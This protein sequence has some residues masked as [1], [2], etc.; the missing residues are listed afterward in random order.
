MTVCTQTAEKMMIIEFDLNIYCKQLIFMYIVVTDSQLMFLIN[1]S[2]N[3]FIIC[4]M[5]IKTI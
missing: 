5:S 1:V 3:D 2:D 4:L